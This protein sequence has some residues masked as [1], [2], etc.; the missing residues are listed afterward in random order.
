MMVILEENKPKGDSDQRLD[1]R[2]QVANL[3]IHQVSP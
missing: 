1:L 2:N 3:S